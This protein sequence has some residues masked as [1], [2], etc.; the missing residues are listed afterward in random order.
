[1]E[2]TRILVQIKAEEHLK[3]SDPLGW[4]ESVYAAANGDE[5]MVPWANLGPTPWLVEWLD[6]NPFPEG[7]RA[8]VVGCG[9]GDDAEELSNRGLT[10]TAFDIS[11]TAIH[12]AKKR[13]PLSQVKYEVADLF[14]A[15]QGWDRYF[16]F[17]FEGYTLQSMQSPLREKAIEKIAG[18]VAPKGDLLVLARGKEPNE[19]PEGPPWPLTQNDLAHFNRYGLSTRAFEDF[20]DKE[21][22]PIRRF[23][24]HYTRT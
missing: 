24:A 14:Q 7:K 3:K 11:P 20:K 19:L 9:L 5:L 23:Q 12:W 1:M 16:G 17:V 15:P 4:F 6:R 10:V 2:V 18:F 22:T 21:K 8:L 13:F